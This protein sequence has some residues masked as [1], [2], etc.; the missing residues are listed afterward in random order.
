MGA[1]AGG[2][3]PS[4]RFPSPLIEPDVR[5][6]RIRLSDWL[7]REAHDGAGKE[8]VRQMVLNSAISFEYFPNMAIRLL[9]NSAMT[10]GDLIVASLWLNSKANVMLACAI[11][12]SF[13]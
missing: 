3:W 13:A 6:Y 9:V 2:Q 11:S 5:R 4:P 8:S 1:V 7:H 12:S 10:P